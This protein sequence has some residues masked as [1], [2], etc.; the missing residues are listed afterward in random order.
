MT[1]YSIKETINLTG[2]TRGLLER[3]AFD[4]K[5]EIHNGMIP[6]AYVDALIQE[7]ETYISLLE[8]ALVFTDPILME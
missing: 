1:E 6:S 3:L 4:E 5:I 7:K 2:C 8:Y